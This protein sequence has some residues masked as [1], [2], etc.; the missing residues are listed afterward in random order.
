MKYNPNNYRLDSEKERILKD[1][2]TVMGGGR[3]IAD[4]LHPTEEKLYSDA[5]MVLMPIVI[6][7]V[8]MLLAIF[9]FAKSAGAP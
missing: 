4:E 6:I 2:E 1:E 9:F 5:L 3:R 7:A 8:G